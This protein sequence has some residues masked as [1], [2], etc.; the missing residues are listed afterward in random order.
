MRGYTVIE[1]LVVI[2][3]IVVLASLTIAGF[4]F[5]T[6]QISLDSSVEQIVETLNLAQNKTV[7]SVSESSYGV[8]F[9]T[10]SFTLF[11]GSSYNP[12]DPANEIFDLANEVEIF[13]IAL[14]GGGQDVIFNRLTGNTKQF[15]Q[16][17]LRL[18]SR[19]AEIKNIYIESSGKIGFAEAPVSTN[20]LIKDSRHVH[21]I[22]DHLI[23][24]STENLILVFSDPP[25]PN[26]E[27][28][29]I[30]K[31]NLTSGNVNWQGTVAV[32]GEPQTLEVK[33]HK[34]NNATTTFSIHRDRRFNNKDL[35]IFISGEP[36]F[37]LINYTAD[38]TTTPGTSDWVS[39]PIW[40]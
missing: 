23:D 32:N 21:F 4:R 17:S 26:V 11:T 40:Q 15:G 33:T 3:I 2:F 8:H 34:L 5:F 10:N 38:G 19:P 24:T 9:A 14:A 39:E 29:I 37:S 22:Y 13:D 1:L 6:H 12:A 18:V 36:G 30:I 35:S 25:N 27:Q 28:E 31:D 20:N 7:A 16:I